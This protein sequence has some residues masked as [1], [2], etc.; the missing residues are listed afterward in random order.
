VSESVVNPSQG[1][2]FDLTTMAID[3]AEAGLGIAI[4]RE[5]QVADMLRKGKL[6]AP[7]RKDL[8][9]GEGC[10]FRTRPERRDEAQISAFRAWLLDEAQR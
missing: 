6:V 3:A 2:T 10:Y 1:L 4:T 8:L 9:R 7:F 5:A